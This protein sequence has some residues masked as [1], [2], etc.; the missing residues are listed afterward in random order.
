MIDKKLSF[1]GAGNMAF[2]CVNGFIENG[3]LGSGCFCVYD[4]DEAKYSNFKK[5][6]VKCAN[7]LEEAL[8]FADFVVLSIKPQVIARCLKDIGGFEVSKNKIFLSFAAGISSDFIISSL[9]FDAPVVRMM[10]NTPFLIGKGT[11]AISKNDLVKR[12]DLQYICT[13]F[14]SVS[15]VTVLDESMMNKVI[16]LNGSSPAYFFY[17]YKSM[18]DVALKFGF[19]DKEARDLILSTMAGSVEMLKKNNDVD[20]LIKN[21]TS[22]GGTTEA[23]L[24]SLSKNNFYNIIEECMIEC[25]NRANELALK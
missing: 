14:A 16:S 23:S 5:L 24:N 10:P 11:V 18:V 1:I 12:K 13:L 8:D 15:S 19:S 22:P 7:S 6:G 17:M 2:A 3:A 21:V 25:T 9:G 20:T 4:V